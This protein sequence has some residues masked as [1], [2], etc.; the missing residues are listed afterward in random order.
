REDSAALGRT[1]AEGFQLQRQSPCAAHPASHAALEIAQRPAREGRRSQR[2]S[3]FQ[4]SRPQGQGERV[5]PFSGGA[6]A[7]TGCWQAGRG[8]LSVSQVVSTIAGLL[9]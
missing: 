5:G 2:Q 7:V 8:R 1:N 6:P 3:L 4:G 9:S